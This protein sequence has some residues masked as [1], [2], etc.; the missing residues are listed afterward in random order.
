MKKLFVV[1]L[2]PGSADTMTAQARAAPGRRPPR[3]SVLLGR[4]VL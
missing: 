3:L 1:G 2:G 4:G